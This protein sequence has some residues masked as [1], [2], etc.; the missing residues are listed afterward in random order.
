M[1]LVKGAL[2]DLS[3]QAI[4]RTSALLAPSLVK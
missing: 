2:T 3:H 4:T 1:N